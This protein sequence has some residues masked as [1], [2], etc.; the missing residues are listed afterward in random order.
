MLF[1]ADA[2]LTAGYLDHVGVP[3]PSELESFMSGA[4]VTGGGGVIA[5]LA[6]TYSPGA[7]GAKH[8]IEAGL[9]TPQ[10]G[11]SGAYSERI[12]QWNFGGW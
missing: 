3:T 11:V 1:S 10:A 8:A 5:G 12:S 2:S 6:W 9:F 7:T 4:T